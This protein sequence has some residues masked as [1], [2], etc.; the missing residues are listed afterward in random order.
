MS[1]MLKNLADPNYVVKFQTLCGLKRGNSSTTLKEEYLDSVR[2]QSED[3]G[4][5]RRKVA[6]HKSSE[7]S[8]A[9][10]EEKEVIN[11]A[12]IY[13]D[14]SLTRES[15]SNQPEGELLYNRYIHSLYFFGSGLGD[16]IFYLTFF[17]LLFWNWDEYIMRRLVVLWVFGMYIGQGLKDVL[18]WPR[19]PSPPVIVVEKKYESEYGMPSTHAIVGSI[20]PFSLV[21]FSY[22]RYEYPWQAGLAFFIFWCG[23]VCL[24]RI[25]MGVHSFQDIVGGLCVAVMVIAICLPF[26]AD[27]SEYMLQNPFT[28]IYLFLGSAGLVIM[29]PSCDK[30]TRARGD[31]TRI[32]CG[33]TGALIAG[34]VTFYVDKTPIP[35]PYEGAPYTLLPSSF[36]FTVSVF[37]I[38][39]LRFVIGI[40]IIIPVKLI[41]SFVIKKILKLFVPNSEET[42]DKKL[43]VELTY[44]FFTYTAVGFAAVYVAP[45]TFNYF[46]LKH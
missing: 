35:D 20:V 6:A 1:E 28:G 15:F 25:Y 23:L 14:D 45:L 13:G 44:I 7:E 34:W 36:N 22:G 12:N 27:G 37:T 2:R 18:R 3:D 11:G 9:A 32:L 24:S 31:T 33:G 19:P 43:F 46:N 4:L 30:W 38:S 10:C 42:L 5:T 16:E 41:F 17:P 40:M 39:L 26:L 8:E 29:Y 21:F